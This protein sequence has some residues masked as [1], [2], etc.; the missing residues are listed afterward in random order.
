MKNKIDFYPKP[1]KCVHCGG[2]VIYTSNEVLYGR[3]YGNGKCYYCTSCGA[4]VGTHNKHPQEPLGMLA[5]PAMKSWKKLCHS[6][7]DPVWKEKHISRSLAYKRLAQKLHIPQ[8]ECH[9]G[10]FDEDRLKEAW[11][12]LKE[13]DWY[14]EV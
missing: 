5:T 3:T 4:S 1:T 13:P 2:K 8:S 12:V 10:H 14:K 7:F 6:L 11:M 9:F